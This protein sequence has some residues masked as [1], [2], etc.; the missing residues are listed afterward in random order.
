MVRIP[1]EL[2]RDLIE[3]AKKKWSKPKSVCNV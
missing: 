2:H 1:K 3:A